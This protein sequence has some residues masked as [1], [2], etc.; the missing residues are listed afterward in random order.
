MRIRWTQP[1]ADDL[2][3]IRAYLAEHFPGFAEPTVRTIYHRILGLKDSPNRGRPGHRIGT[4]ELVLSPIP[5]VVVYRVQTEA[6]E[7]LHI[8]HGAQDWRS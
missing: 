5:Y 2:G 7:I 4:R 8:H 3:K 6:V 1:A